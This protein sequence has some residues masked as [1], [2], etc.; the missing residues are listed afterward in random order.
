MWAHPGK[1]LLFMGGE[2]AQDNEWSE[3]RE[4]DWWLLDDPS[5]AGVQS[6]VRDLNAAYRGTPALFRTDT[7][8]DGFDWIDAND[9]ANN[10]FSFVRSFAGERLACVANF[11]AVP[12]ER[13][14]IGLPAAG[15]WTELINTDAES[16]RGSGVGNLGAVSAEDSPWHGQPASAVVTLPPLATLWLRHDA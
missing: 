14:R 1:Q 11:A 5:H 16:Y 10:T 7:D 13:Y 8:P 12:H 15:T 3:E 4:L 6:L 2:I 9:S